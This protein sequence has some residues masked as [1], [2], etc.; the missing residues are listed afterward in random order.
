MLL[1]QMSGGEFYKTPPSEIS[2]LREFYDNCGSIEA[3]YAYYLSGVLLASSRVSQ[4][5]AIGPVICDRYIYTTIAYHQAMGLVV[6][7]IDH[8]RLPL[9]R[10]DHCICLTASE[11]VIRERLRE[12]DGNASI[13]GRAAKAAFMQ[14][15]SET[16]KGMATAAI[17]TSKLSESEVAARI[18]QMVFK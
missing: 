17:D 3:R 7:W 10:P 18:Y 2:S 9:L 8:E 13:E 12:R 4:L 5:L 15:V 14:R 1:A 6:D 11:E 16:L